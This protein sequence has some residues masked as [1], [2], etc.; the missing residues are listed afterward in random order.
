MTS[1]SKY[2]PDKIHAAV[3]DFDQRIDRLEHLADWL[4]DEADRAE[5]ESLQI[6]SRKAN[7]LALLADDIKVGGSE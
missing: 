4:R 5:R 6:Q 7:V 2:D 3:A 1:R